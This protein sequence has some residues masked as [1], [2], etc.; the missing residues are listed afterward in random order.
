MANEYAGRKDQ[1]RGNE[2]SRALAQK[3]AYKQNVD[4]DNRALAQKPANKQNVDLDNQET[5]SEI[6]VSETACLLQINGGLLF[7]ELII[8]QQKDTQIS[9]LVTK[10]LQ[11]KGKTQLTKVDQQF[12][13]THK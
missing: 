11:M 4:F 12:F 3:P 6:M 7:E 1:V 13:N 5:L 10:W 8:S 9:D 2:L